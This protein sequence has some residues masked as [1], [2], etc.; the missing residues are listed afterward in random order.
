M[1]T[2]IKVNEYIKFI[3][4]INFNRDLYYYINIFRKLNKFLNKNK[5]D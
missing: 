4:Y 1:F 2:L 3:Y 5:N